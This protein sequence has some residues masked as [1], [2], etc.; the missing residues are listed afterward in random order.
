[1]IALLDYIDSLKRQDNKVEEIA[2]FIDVMTRQV[3]FID[4]LQIE[5]DLETRMQFWQMRNWPRIFDKWLK[6]RR[7]QLLEQKELL[8]DQMTVECRNVKE[9]VADFKLTIKEMLTRGLTVLD[10]TKAERRELKLK[11]LFVKMAPN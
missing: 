8:I 11:E 7:Q 3:E 2:D 1:V 5:F 10:S 6:E 9:M 4:S